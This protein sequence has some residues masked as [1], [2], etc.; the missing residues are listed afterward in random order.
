M[1]GVAST[2]SI[3]CVVPTLLALLLMLAACILLLIDA[4]RGKTRPRR[5]DLAALCCIVA[6]LAMA[7]WSNTLPR[8]SQWSPR[9]QGDDNVWRR[10][11]LTP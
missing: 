4:C 9:W 10:Q 7:A 2:S 6:A 11:D 5:R 8:P 3:S 1:L